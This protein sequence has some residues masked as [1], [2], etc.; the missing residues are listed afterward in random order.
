[1]PR[2]EQVVFDLLRTDALGSDRLIYP[3]IHFFP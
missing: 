2:T 3:A 1:M